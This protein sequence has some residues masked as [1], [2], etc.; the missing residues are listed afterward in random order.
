[1][2]LLKAAVFLLF[3]TTMGAP[4]EERPKH[5]THVPMCL[6]QQHLHQQHIKKSESYGKPINM[7]GRFS[8]VLGHRYT[9]RVLEG[10]KSIQLEKEMTSLK[11]CLSPSCAFC[12][13]AL[14]IKSMEERAP[15]SVQAASQYSQQKGLYQQHIFLRQPYQ[16]SVT[17]ATAAMITIQLIMQQY[18][19][20]R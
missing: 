8:S 20:M 7:R 14:V 5:V 2:G 17:Y 19:A 9:A 15:T 6:H 13:C 18:A 3:Y 1:M 4:A 10:S 11:I 12:F 16:D